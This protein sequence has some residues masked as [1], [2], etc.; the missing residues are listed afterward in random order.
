LADRCVSFYPP[1]P[2]LVSPGAGSCHHIREGC[3][4]INRRATGGSRIWR[5]H[6]NSE[7]RHIARRRPQVNARE[8]GMSPCFSHDH[9]YQPPVI[10]SGHRRMS[11]PISVGAIDGVAL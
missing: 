6:A 1:V 5:V 9:S 4:A 8:R 11:C 7:R 3:A 2:G 10:R